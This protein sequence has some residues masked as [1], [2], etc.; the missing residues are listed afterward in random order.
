MQMVIDKLGVKVGERFKL[1]CGDYI[2]DG[3]YHFDIDGLL[4][5][6]NNVDYSYYSIRLV[7]GE[8]QIEKLPFK[9]GSQQKYQTVNDYGDVIVTHWW[10][11]TVDYYRFNA[12]NCFRKEE[13]ITE[14]DK[15]RIIAEMKS[16][17]ES[18]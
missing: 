7:L 18:E 11:N 15:K 14:E 5:N 10:G 12:K 4:Q 17:Y 1:R 8:Y 16:K 6:E 13:K 9:P 2:V 3:S